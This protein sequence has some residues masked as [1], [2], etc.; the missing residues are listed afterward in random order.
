MFQELQP[1]LKNRMLLIT[2]ASEGDQMRVNIMPKALSADKSGELNQAQSTPLS[3]LATAD[4]LD[5]EL[6]RLLGG[7]VAQ[8]QKLDESLAQFEKDIE[9]AKKEAGVKA[10][11]RAAAARKVGARTVKPTAP[12]AAPAPETTL[13]QPGLFPEEQGAPVAAKA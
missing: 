3:V 12:A 8:H 6:P 1:L 2:V 10:G 11:E 5:R 13:K 9:E 4:E 7:F